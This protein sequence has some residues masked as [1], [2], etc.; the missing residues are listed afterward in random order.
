MRA[1]VLC[2]VLG[3][4]LWAPAV[5]RSQAAAGNTDE[6]PPPEP[7]RVTGHITCADTQRPARVAQVRLVPVP[8]LAAGTQKAPVA[9]MSA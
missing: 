8:A 1:R 4:A 3:V 6:P 2:F 7:G 9:K 5:C